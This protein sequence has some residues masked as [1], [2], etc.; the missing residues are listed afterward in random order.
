MNATVKKILAV[1]TA[2]CMAALVCVPAFAGLTGDYSAPIPTVYLHGQGGVIY[3]DKDNPKSEKIQD[4]SVPDG[5]IED[6]GK[7]LIGPLAKGMFFNQ[8]NDWVDTFVEGVA[9]LL[10]KQALELKAKAN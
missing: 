1:L 4:I 9:P 3:A 7:A 10:E 2:A 6:L 5:Y 8:W